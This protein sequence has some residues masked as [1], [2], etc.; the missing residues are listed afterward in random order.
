MAVLVRSDDSGR[1][2]EVWRQSV[3]VL[4]RSDDTLTR[5]LTRNNRCPIK[6]IDLWMPLMTF[7]R[8]HLS[9]PW[10]AMITLTGMAMNLQDE[11]AT[12]EKLWHGT[13]TGTRH[14]Y[15]SCL[16]F[17]SR[18]LH[19]RC[20]HLRAHAAALSV[21]VMRFSGEQGS[22]SSR[23]QRRWAIVFSLPQSQLTVCMLSM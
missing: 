17:F 4:V 12:R 23:Q 20:C 14:R 21:M 16:F 2:S 10:Y 1:I 7:S 11:G 15:C 18:V 8:A 6:E 19:T 9:M 22:S 3:A 5:S 13:A